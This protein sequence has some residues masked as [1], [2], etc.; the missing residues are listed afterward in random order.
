VD[1]DLFERAR[2]YNDEFYIERGSGYHHYSEVLEVASLLWK[3][4]KDVVNDDAP[5]VAVYSFANLFEFRLPQASFD[6]L[7]SYLGMIQQP[8]AAAMNFNSSST[9]NRTP[10]HT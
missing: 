10:T 5:E 6:A 1:D 2:R 7:I 3:S 9:P 8:V 4:L